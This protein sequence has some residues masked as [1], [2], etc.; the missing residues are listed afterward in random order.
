LLADKFPELV[1]K[2]TFSL[3]WDQ[4]KAWCPKSKRV[5][6]VPDPK[7]IEKLLCEIV[8]SEQVEQ[9][10]TQEVCE[11]L[12]DKMPQQACEE[13]LNLLWDKIKA[14]CSK[15][16]KATAS[17]P[18]TEEIKKFVCE[19][20]SP[21]QIEREATQEV[22]KLLA[23]KFPEQECE[24]IVGSLW[25]KVKAWCP[26]AKKATV[27]WPQ[28]EKAEELMCEIA[29]SERVEPEAV[30]QICKVLVDQFPSQDNCETAVGLLWEE[31]KAE[32]PKAT[33]GARGIPD[34]KKIKDFVCGMASS[35]QVEQQATQ[36]ICRIWGDQFPSKEVC[37]DSVKFV[38]DEIKAKC[39]SV[40]TSP[41]SAMALEENHKVA[42]EL[43]SF[44]QIQRGATREVCEVLADALPGPFL[45]APTLAKVWN[46]V[47]KVCAELAPAPLAIVI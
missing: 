40:P 3:L 31:I 35:A 12:E 15:A 30:E 1:C 21:E 23:D 37:E 19:L 46:K 7:E 25:D 43:G 13:A 39:A 6:V 20:A 11:L 32:C 17:V 29:T 33:V 28:S 5:A 34:P 8:S 42:C 4:V 45:C 18:D 22:C 38:W 41:W 10:A 24:E 14:W 27:A 9:E 16:K 36:E 2:E 44:E 47:G 26:K